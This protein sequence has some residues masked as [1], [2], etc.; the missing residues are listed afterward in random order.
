MTFEE[1]KAKLED[2]LTK[3]EEGAKITADALMH[4]DEVEDQPSESQMEEVQ[5]RMM[6]KMVRCQKVFE[7]MGRAVQ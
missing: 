4:A 2:G 6:L 1:W 7:E 3:L 5:V